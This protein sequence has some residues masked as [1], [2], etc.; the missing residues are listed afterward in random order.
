MR[1]FPYSCCRLIHTE[2][3][4]LCGINSKIDPRKEAEGQ[5]TTEVGPF[6]A[7]GSL[8]LVWASVGFGSLLIP[9]WR[10]SQMCLPAHLDR[11]GQGTFEQKGVIRTSMVLCSARPSVKPNS[12]ATGGG[13][14][15]VLG[16]ESGGHCILGQPLGPPHTKL[17]SLVHPLSSMA[18][19]GT[20]SQQ[21]L[22]GS[23]SPLGM[24]VNAGLPRLMGYALKYTRQSCTR[25]NH[26]VSE[27]NTVAIEKW[28]L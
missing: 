2:Q 19:P 13:R 12:S 26:P 1:P 6:C 4:G 9:R 7:D 5:V 21:V 23:V 20:P 8:P 10:T 16:R 15:N 14:P 18:I 17:R 27:A 11:S 3:C 22:K 24:F 25:T 28:P